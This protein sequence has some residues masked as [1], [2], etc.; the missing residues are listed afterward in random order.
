MECPNWWGVLIGIGVKYSDWNVCLCGCKRFSEA[1]S[2]QIPVIVCSFSS[3][4]DG[5]QG[6]HIWIFYSHFLPLPTHIYIHISQLDPEF[7]QYP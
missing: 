7:F 3:D 1:H 5:G 6:A 4:F 2:V